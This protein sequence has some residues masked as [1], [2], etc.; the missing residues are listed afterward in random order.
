MFNK[1]ITI[2][3]QGFGNESFALSFAKEMGSILIIV[4]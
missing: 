4:V 2:L 3:S 1:K